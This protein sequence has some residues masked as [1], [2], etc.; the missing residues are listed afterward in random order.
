[1]CKK[2]GTIRLL[3]EPAPEMCMHDAT[4]Y[5]SAS[6]WPRVA[7]LRPVLGPVLRPV[8]LLALS[9]AAPAAAQGR[10]QV[11]MCAPPCPT[12]AAC[13][14]TRPAPCGARI[15]RRSSNTRVQLRD[16]VLRY[17]VTEVFRNTGSRGGEADYMFPLPAGAA[18]EDLKLSINGELVS[19]ETMGADRARGIYEDI[20]RRQRDPALVEWM[21]NGMLRARIFPIQPGE[22]KTV[23]VR[24][25]SVAAREG[26][27]L[28]VDVRR[29]GDVLLEYPNT[30]EYGNAYSPTH[31]LTEGPDGRV[32]RVEARATGGDFTVL[33]PLRRADVAGLSVLTHAVRDEPGFAML[34]IA[35]P[36]NTERATPRDLTFV[37]D[38]SGSMQGRKL[39]QAKAA[40]VALLATLRPTDRFR[41]I[42][43]S[44]DVRT[45]RDG[46]VD[47][48]PSQLREARHHLEQLSAEGSTNISDALRTALARDGSSNERLP[49]VVFLTDGEPTVGERNPDAIAAIA[50]R[51]RG[52]ARVFTVGVGTGVNAMLVEQL[53]L[54][55]RGTAHFVRDDDSV[56]APVSLL[57][58]RLSEPVLTDVRITA[59]GVRLRQVMPSG[60]IDI[61]AGQDLVLLARYD[62]NGDAT[63]DFQ[64]RGPN[65]PVSWS[66]RA[67]FTDESHSNAFVPRLWAAQRIGWL[68]AEKRRTAGSGN[69]RTS[70]ELDHEIRMLGERYGIPTEFS[71]Y[72]VVEP[73][74]AVS[75]GASN[76]R[77]SAMISAAEARFESVRNASLQRDA[78]SLSA[79]DGLA[80]RARSTVD[81][82]TIGTRR[83]TVVSG[84]WTDI[85]YTSGMRTVS[86]R[87]F[88]PLYFE[89]LRRMPELQD[90]FALGDRVIVAGR[91]VAIALV[92]DGS[93]Q[94]NARVFADLTRDW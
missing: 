10:M 68:A 89:L 15:E 18:F 49:L 60:P 93:A 13:T 48:T 9:A 16:R 34:T 26:D 59:R 4:R 28:R 5:P 31:A 41:L 67:H 77:P 44:T 83:L 23:V 75:N 57:A 22:D 52:S 25:Q 24:Y 58:R 87:P 30:T 11:R 63:I 7:A 17:E 56:E 64:G 94:V 29:G 74:M 86:V 32:R 21:G 55:G 85:R 20:V 35:P 8:L 72:L 51:L 66:T 61:F 65:G 39:E 90:L 37:L 73:G 45:Y 3:R 62:G 69:G 40:G 27:A 84:V 46:W 36:A 92:A 33:L 80:D 81:V 91:A 12:E 43:F 78:K 71:S 79:V 19:G 88:S 76:T 54:Q 6:S 70:Q 42:D 38:V 82:R 53:A 47:A 50:A 14:V 1:M 2:I